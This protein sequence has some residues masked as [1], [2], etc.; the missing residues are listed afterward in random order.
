[1]AV[2]SWRRCG[3]LAPYTRAGYSSV[4]GLGDFA[5]SQRF[6]PAVLW[7]YGMPLK[8]RTPSETYPRTF[9]YCVFATAERGVEQ[10]LEAWAPGFVPSADRTGIAIA[11]P[12][13]AAGSNS[14]RRRLICFRSF[15]L[16]MNPPSVRQ[17]RSFSISSICREP[18]LVAEI[19]P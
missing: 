19:L 15:D 18:T 10:V 14:A 12:R 5:G 17:N 6:S 2:K 3:Q 13:P 7:P 4:Q 9:P 16:G 8:V 1:M 11:A